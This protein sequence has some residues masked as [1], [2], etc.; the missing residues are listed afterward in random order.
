MLA[1]SLS[2]YMLDRPEVQHGTAKS[3]LFVTLEETIPT[4][5]TPVPHHRLVAGWRGMVALLR[6]R[7]AATFEGY[8]LP[9]DPVCAKTCPH[10]P[11]HHP[12]H[13]PRL[14]HAPDPA[15]GDD[16]T[17]ATFTDLLFNQRWATSRGPLRTTWHAGPAAELDCGDT[18]VLAAVPSFDGRRALWRA[19][20]GVEQLSGEPSEYANVE[21]FTLDQLIAW[22][23]GSGYA[24]ECRLLSPEEERDLLDVAEVRAGNLQPLPRND[25]MARVWGLCW[26]EY[27]GR[28]VAIETQGAR[29][30]THARLC[31]PSSLL[32]KGACSR[33][34]PRPAPPPASSSYRSAKLVYQDAPKS[35][36]VTGFA[37]NGDSST[38]PDF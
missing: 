35:L 4:S 13:C 28:I 20:D 38:R 1:R 3:T 37:K 16:V 33:A 23:S 27:E 36:P 24:R 12:G 15:K 34:R 2:R 21:P 18:E 32:R 19:V 29:T 31:A 8:L 14:R 9:A 10:A 22:N 6:D 30:E 11:L 5:K 17:R 7:R 25:P 26:P